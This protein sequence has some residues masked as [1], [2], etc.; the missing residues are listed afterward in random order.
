MPR[1]VALAV[2]L[3]SLIGAGPVARA[4]DDAGAFVAPLD[5]VFTMGGW[6]VVSGSAFDLADLSQA[7]YLRAGGS[8]VYGG[9]EGSRVAVIVMVTEDSGAAARNSWQIGNDLFDELRSSFDWGF[10]SERELDAQP[11]PIGCADMRRVEGEDDAL[12]SIPVAVSLCA[13]DP[14]VIVLAY[15][16]GSWNGQEGY[17]AADAVV[18]TVLRAR[19]VFSPAA[20]PVAIR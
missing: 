19:T 20:T 7:P 4:Q 6:F 8:R 13:A 11:A 10:G 12:A 9:P 15:V 18:A 2:V 5:T 3:A 1:L 16:S 17:R 14:N